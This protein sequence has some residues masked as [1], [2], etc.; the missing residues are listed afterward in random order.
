M[1]SITLNI[2]FDMSSE[3]WEKLSDVYRSM[4]GWQGYVIDGC[5]V[6]C[7]LI[8]NK[9]NISASVEP[10]GLLIEG[11]F[12]ESEFNHWITVFMDSA[13]LALGF[14]VKDAES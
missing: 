7:S 11:D 1:V 14:Q 6:W 13:S 5:P 12:S 4:S 9:R 3:S 10:S 2:P 8:E